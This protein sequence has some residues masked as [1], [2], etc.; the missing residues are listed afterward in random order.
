MRWTLEMNNEALHRK[1]EIEGVLEKRES[2]KE[3]SLKL[4][5]S[6]RFLRRIRS[7]IARIAWGAEPPIS[8]MYLAT[9]PCS[10]DK[11]NQSNREFGI[12]LDWIGSLYIMATLT[13]NSIKYSVFQ[14]L[15]NSRLSYAT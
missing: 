2:Q 8:W 5:I 3:A 14:P 7:I 6:E 15:Y 13:T 12:L 9:F 11:K 4:G 1:S 10:L